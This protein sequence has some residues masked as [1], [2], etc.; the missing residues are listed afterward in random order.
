[1]PNNPNLIEINNLSVLFKGENGQH[2]AVQNVNL[3]LK[4]GETVGIVG[5]SGSG[6]TVTSLAMMRLLPNAPYCTTEGEILFNS[7]QHGRGKFAQ[8]A[9]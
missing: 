3:K 6:K 9:F 8:N 5:E 7:R 4:K 2:K 1:M